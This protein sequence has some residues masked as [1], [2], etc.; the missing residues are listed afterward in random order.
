MASPPAYEHEQAPLGP[1]HL[2]DPLGPADADCTTSPLETESDSTATDDHDHDD[3]DAHARAERL[4]EDQQLLEALKRDGFQGRLWK[5]FVDRLA[6]YGFEIIRV[7]VLNM[8]IVP[9]AAKKGVKGVRG[10]G[11][12]GRPFTKDAADQLA[13]DT[14]EA[15]IR[16]FRR[17]VLIPGR[18]SP[19]GGASLNSYFLGQCLFEFPNAYRRWRHANRP[20][21]EESLYVQVDDDDDD[22]DSMTGVLVQPVDL[23]PTSDSARVVQARDEVLYALKDVVQSD[24]DQVIVAL[25]A[26]GYTEREIADMLDMTLK[27]VEGALY[28]L[29]KRA[30]SHQVA[31]RPRERRETHGS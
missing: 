27:A 16:A 22:D 11:P 20:R 21:P 15:A 29:H 7:W 19:T 28:R 8:R 25:R 6:R 5:R 12:D 31:R 30:N 23:S 24:R 1:V 18:W 4:A 2:S 17:K 9:E 14:V 10:S 3:H 26:A 13:A